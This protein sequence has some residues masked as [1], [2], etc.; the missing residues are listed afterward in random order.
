MGLT[1]MLTSRS[2]L[3]F[4]VEQNATY[5]SAWLEMLAMRFFLETSATYRWAQYA[6][7]NASTYPVQT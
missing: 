3:H 6:S 4:G 2:S 1:Y 7:L 5:L